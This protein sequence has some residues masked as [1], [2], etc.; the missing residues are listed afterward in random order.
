MCCAHALAT[1]A[2][3]LL[4]QALTSAEDTVDGATWTRAADTR[5]ALEAMDQALGFAEGAQ[6]ALRS[7]EDSSM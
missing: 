7:D 1:A 2:R 4:R 5:S 6:P 3:T